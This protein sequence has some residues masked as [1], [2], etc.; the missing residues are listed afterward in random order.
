MST[1]ACSSSTIASTPVGP[2]DLQA[3]SI[4]SMLRPQPRVV[5]AR[6]AVDESVL[7]SFAGGSDG[8]GPQ[9]GLLKFHGK[10]Y[11]TTAGGGGVDDDGTVF[12]ITKTG[13][14]KV[15]YS[16]QGGSDGATPEESLVEV[17]GALYGA[18]RFG[19]IGHGTVFRITTA[20][21]ETVL[22]RFQGD[23]DGLSPTSLI[24]VG[25][26]LYGTTQS[27]G[28][29][30]QGTVFKI[31][32]NGAYTLLHSFE[33]NYSDG[34]SPTGPLISVA[35]TLYGTTDFGGLNGYGTVFKI[36]ESGSESLLYSFDQF[37]GFNPYGGLIDVG[38]VLYGMTTYGGK[39]DVGTVFKITTGGVLTNL[40]DFA[41]GSD[42]ALPFG[43]LTKVGGTLYGTTARGGDNACQDSSLSGCGTIFGI[44]P[45]G[46]YSQLYQFTS[47]SDGAVP[48]GNL[49]NVN[50]KLYG[51]TNG[52]GAK[53]D[54]TVFSFAP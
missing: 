52:G 41:G 18:T 42:G 36:T 4:R 50:G 7:Y 47:G 22:Y 46:E 16:F 2:S 15:L 17:G 30:G 27:G 43:G 3:S 11:G 29:Y 1:T 9:A 35:G 54:G 45:G 5:S 51:M 31:T 40:Y 53:N 6:P 13:K 8:A 33:N 37:G 12:E 10:L 21:E 34:Q 28:A 32:T 48:V 24:A 44:T 23:P 20:G 25:D 26:T 38:G 14:E 39:S 49:T 19:G